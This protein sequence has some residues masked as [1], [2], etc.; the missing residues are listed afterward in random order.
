MHAKLTCLWL[1]EIRIDVW[2]NFNFFNTFK[3]FMSISTLHQI[4]LGIPG[5][6][7]IN[8]AVSLH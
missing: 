2:N 8:M 3:T 7:A 1:N 6:D 4:L 5:I